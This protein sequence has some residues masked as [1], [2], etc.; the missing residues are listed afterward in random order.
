MKKLLTITLLSA[1]MAVSGQSLKR[2]HVFYDTVKTI[3]TKVKRIDFSP[4][5]I[6]IFFKEL[7]IKSNSVTEQWV[8]GFVI[9]QTFKKG[10][11]TSDHFIIK[12]GNLYG[13]S[14]L[15]SS[16]EDTID[17][18]YVNEYKESINILTDK[19]LYA[20]RS[21]VTNKVISTLKR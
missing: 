3:Q 19:F 14:L 9:W 11:W 2:Q 17:G 21:K 10:T 5:T 4:D 12:N 13:T 1:A 20:D 7:V 8:S 15:S 16:T 18:Y 6:P